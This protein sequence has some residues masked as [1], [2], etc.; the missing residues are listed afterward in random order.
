MYMH[1]IIICSTGIYLVPLD[2]NK[3]AT[4]S[5]SVGLTAKQFALNLPRLGMYYPCRPHPPE[6]QRPMS[7]GGP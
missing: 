4:I 3:L 1:R 5:T 7:I 2:T 6:S